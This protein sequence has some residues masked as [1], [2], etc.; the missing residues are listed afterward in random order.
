[1]MTALTGRGNK[2]SLFYV[3]YTSNL[4]HKNDAINKKRKFYSL[5]Q[6]IL[7]VIGLRKPFADATCTYPR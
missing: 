2:V 3:D 7:S 5:I 1:M 6:D 4:N